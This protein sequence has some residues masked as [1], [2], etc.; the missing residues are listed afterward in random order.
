MLTQPEIER[1]HA[2][3]EQMNTNKKIQVI[4][5]MQWFMYDDDLHHP[6]TQ[7]PLVGNKPRTDHVDA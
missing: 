7:V 4:V 1:V 2:V 5:R 3:Y 6:Q